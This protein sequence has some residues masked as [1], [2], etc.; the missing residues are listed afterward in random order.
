M[1]IGRMGSVAR[2]LCV[3]AVLA[4]GLVRAEGV[5][6]VALMVHRPSNSLAWN[7]QPDE[8][9]FMLGCD[10]LLREVVGRTNV[11]RK[12][13]A[14]R[15]NGI[16]QAMDAGLCFPVGETLY[17]KWRPF[18]EA[19]VYIA[20][21]FS[22]ER[23]QWRAGTAAGDRFDS[24]VIEQPYRRPQA[25]AAA[26]IKLVF[27][28]AE[29]DLPPDWIAALEGREPS[30]PALFIEWA[31]WIGYQPH[32]AH[33]GPWLAPQASA[34]RI[35]NEDAAFA[36]GA[37]WALEMI[38]R[39]ASRFTFRN[40]DQPSP[41]SALQ[42]P[43]ALGL[44]DTPYADAAFPFLQR[45]APKS[46][47][48]PQVLELFDLPLLNM[49]I[50]LEEHPEVDATA[51][52]VDIGEL[53]ARLG[54]P[55][56]RRNLVRA[57]GPLNEKPVLEALVM[58]LKEDG[59]PG[60]RAE[61]ARLCATHHKGCEAAL[62]EVFHDDPAP[63]ARAAAWA[64]LARLGAVTAADLARATADASPAVR[65]AL[66]EHLGRVAIPEEER[67][68]LW[69][70]LIDD[71][72]AG[73][74]LAAVTRLRND[75]D[76]PP[77]A[78]AVRA[79]ALRALTSGAAS[80]QRAVLDWIA[81]RP[82]AVF[83]ESLRPLLAH[84]DAGVR[85][86]AVSALA[87]VAP[88]QLAAS[89]SALRRDAAAPVQA[90]LAE[91]L[92]DTAPPE[93]RQ[94]LFDLLKTARP[95][96]R[97][98][99]VSALYRVLGADRAALARAMPFDTAQVVNL[100]ALRLAE[101]LGDAA[102]LREV[103]EGCA[104]SHP[105]PYIRAEALR[106]M[107]RH[108]LPSLRTRCLAGIA[109]PFWVVRL[110]AADILGRLAEPADAPVLSAACGAAQNAW[111]RLAL[112][113]ALAKAQG[114]PRPERVRLGLGDRA[115]TEGGDRPAGF[116]VWRSMP[117]SDPAERRRLVSEGYRFGTTVAPAN[118]PGGMVLNVYNS[119]ESVRN[120]YLLES[121]LA[122]LEALKE[123]L[124]Y[125]YYLALF[126]EPGT[127]GTGFDHDRVRAMVLEAGR[128]DL[129]TAVAKDPEAGLPEE[130]RRAYV[131]YNARFG[132]L[133]SNWV[134][135][136]F[137]L[138]GQRLYP[139]L[140]I[141]PQSLTYMGADTKD[142][143]DLIDADGD[144]TWDYYNGTFF[145]DGG[146][147]AMNRVLN[148]GKPLNKITWMGWHRPSTLTG[149]TLT[150]KSD[151]PDGPWRLR[152]YLG[153]RSALALWA[154]GTEPGFFTGVGFEKVS[155]KQTKGTLEAPKAGLFDYKPWS[156]PARALVDWMLDDP[157]YWRSREGVIAVEQLK[158]AGG[159][160]GE[161]PATVGDSPFADADEAMRFLEGGPTPL[162]KAVAAARDVMREQVLTGLGYMN[163][164]NTDT[165]RSLANLPKPD[166]RRRDTLIILGR[167]TVSHTDGAAFPIPAIAV[168][169]GYDLLPTYDGIG[170]ADLL[171]YDTILLRASRDGVTA[172]LVAA[173]SRW[174]REKRNGLLVVSGPVT[175][176]HV[177]FPALTLDRIEAPL[178]W[179][180]EVQITV[181]EPVT[182]TSRDG[183]GREQTRQASPPPLAFQCP[184]Q[185][186]AEDT[187][188]RVQCTFAGAVEPLI[189]TDAGEALL[190]RWRAP[191]AVTSVVLFDGADE[192][193]PAYTEALET[194]I[195]A[196][197]RA[198]GSSVA[199]NRWW[200]HTVY[201]NDQYVVDV[202]SPQLRSL[203]AARPR[204]HA[205]VDVISGVINPE[206]RQGE[207]ALILK[208]YVGPYAG[209]RGN[210]AVL[211][212][213]ALKAMTVHDD[214]RLTVEAVGVTRVTRIG[215][216]PIR[217]ENPDGFERVEH[218][219]RVWQRMGE[220]KPTYSLNAIE[221]GHELHLFSPRPFT[222]V[223]VRE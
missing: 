102:V 132:A 100:A 166:T 216:E 117:P 192:A 26:L 15:I 200:G 10:A 27:E 16:V 112:E 78:A 20:A 6:H 107:E 64:G 71:P 186:R 160:P 215:P 25:A 154:T 164:F 163:L 156:A 87:R 213:Q 92:A 34:M 62:R 144:Y 150:L 111:L 8:A 61:A 114:R 174:M 97:A 138:T 68:A 218:Q 74:R 119:N 115:H 211:A 56:V 130:L 52:P 73:V 110:E 41:A 178:P 135:H 81:A 79:P 104:D 84:A 2:V 209:G 184:G 137:R 173:V 187:E 63:E 106:L 13:G 77:A 91:A 53:K 140:R 197:D 176:E 158:K 198:R 116:Q 57:L 30:P 18:L 188:T 207:S 36:P 42:L 7:G 168:V 83:A 203:Q 142:A 219:I 185:A 72:D 120:I 109:S 9:A 122:P 5:R 94:I 155:G 89:V 152:G 153:V 165:T 21:E 182:E 29:T 118:M 131:W 47:M 147:G 221:G 143:F 180:R 51:K 141:F 190:A 196:I 17:E 82:D 11:I 128:P 205:G 126:D 22:R 223:A 44:L 193:G 43:Q 35:L 19:D 23:L 66:A 48:L 103:L 70:R 136:M 85:A 31:K 60:V 108:A 123:V 45:H 38:L 139:D 181:R 46:G 4:T 124:P 177:L 212:R 167:D 129:L 12:V 39:D 99:V 157:L 121:V 96:V 179:E 76:L 65:E 145:G 33:H 95:D 101:R 125:L 161:G 105:N 28:A 149:D 214:G 220:G 191:A 67:V 37:A 208:D 194:T 59:D 3:A 40:G 75:T 171:H 14:N 32:W 195:L 172:D 54:G 162:E 189:T 134:V 133:A 90:A 210:W 222:V 170:A 148:P 88:G 93:A 217:L 127:L 80:E 175:S 113:D 201:E 50:V 199:R 55:R 206:V 183:R 98:T 1:R 58:L 151:F 146:I 49:E 69:M 169:Q 202:A 86:A 24:P 204:R 159:R